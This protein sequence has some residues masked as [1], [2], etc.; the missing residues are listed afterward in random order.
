MKSRYLSLDELRHMTPVFMYF[1]LIDKEGEFGLS[2]MKSSKDGYIHRHDGFNNFRRKLTKIPDNARLDNTPSND[3]IKSFFYDETKTRFCFET[4]EIPPNAHGDKYQIVFNG[5][6]PYVVYI[7]KGIFVY[8]VPNNKYMDDSDY[9]NPIYLENKDIIYTELVWSCANP[10][11]IFIGEDKCVKKHG[12]NILVQLQE[13]LYMHIGCQIYMFESNDQITDFY[14]RMGN[15]SVPYPVALTKDC[16]IFM[17]DKDIVKKCD[18]KSFD[19]VP[20]ENGV[21]QWD[22]SYGAYY[23]IKRYNPSVI[24]PIK[25]VYPY[26]PMNVIK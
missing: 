9:D 1:T 20:I 15:N 25:M 13:T 11:K 18:L 21:I 17:G 6:V 16:A 10:M 12:N 8:R 26:L 4:L 24:T 23:D 14:S 19:N 2:G 7:N 22:D 5:G 3:W